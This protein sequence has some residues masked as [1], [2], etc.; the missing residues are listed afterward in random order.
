M[1]IEMNWKLFLDQASLDAG[2]NQA[3]IDE[4]AIQMMTLHSAKGLVISVGF[5][6][7]M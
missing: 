4:D 2:E 7:W 3:D 5:Y 6:G 1:M